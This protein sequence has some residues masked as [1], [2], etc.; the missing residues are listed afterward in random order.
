MMNYKKYRPYPT[1]HLKNRKWPDNVITKAP[2]WCSVDLRD[3]NQA[4]PIPMSVTE[5]MEMFNLLLSIGFKE[6]EIGFPSASNTEYNF[7]RTL[8]E[9]NLIPDGVSIQVLT[10]A[11]AHL[12][13]K[14]LESLK[15]VKKAIVHFYNST[16]ELQRRVV[17]NKNKEE[18]KQIAVDGAKLIR[19]IAEKNNMSQN[20]VYQYSPES[21]TG[22][23]ID[24]AIEVCEAVVDVLEPTKEKK[25]IINLPATIEM[26]TPNIY[27]DQIEYFSKNFR[28]RDRIILSIHNHNDRGT[29]VAAAELAILAGA[30]RVEGTLFGNGERTGNLD[31]LTLALNMFSQGIDPELDFSNINRIIEIYE[32]NTRMTV[33]PRHPYAGKLVYTAFSGSHQDAISKGMAYY[34]KYKPPYWEVPYLPIDPSDLGREYEP[35]IRINSQSGK[36][37]V[38]YIMETEFGYKLP[39]E[40]HI[41]FGSIIKEESDKLGVELT[42]QQIYD[43]FKKEY[44]DIENPLKLKKYEM[45]DVEFIDDEKSNKVKIS[46]DIIINTEEKRLNGEGNGPIDAFFN[47]LK[48]E[49]TDR[50][51]NSFKFISYLEHALTEGSD[52]KAVA[53]IEIE[54]QEGEKFFGVGVASNITTASI[55]AVISAV[56][57]AIKYSK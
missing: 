24:Y 35:I 52:S 13:E 44:L 54:N 55:K 53:Y 3:G 42:P 29:A 28:K 27:A 57:R 22:T 4:L 6:I 36:G 1:I 7:A 17:F 5:K 46:I 30:E 26:S 32:K 2:I 25:V 20:L 39:K 8:I 40:M 51:F 37:G 34:N 10:Q 18:I 47:I 41:E 16:S 15:G 12:I 9:E 56:N 50:N 49:L 33:H 48:K 31:I 38:A 19:E 14:T 45:E 11:R 43:I 21:F 23:E